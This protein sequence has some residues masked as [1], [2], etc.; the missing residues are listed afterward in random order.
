MILVFVLGMYSYYFPIAP[1]EPSYE[2]IDP[3]YI[4]EFK[5]SSSSK[6]ALKYSAS[7]SLISSSSDFSLSS[8]S[9]C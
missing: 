9:G 6:L 3:S 7:L 8:S 1:S 2:D 5:T 4:C